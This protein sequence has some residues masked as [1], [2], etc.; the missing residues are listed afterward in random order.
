[1]VCHLFFSFPIS[2]NMQLPSSVTTLAF[3]INSSRYLI[4]VGYVVLLWDTILTFP[5]E[6]ER[7]WRSGISLPKIVFLANK[8]ASLSILTVL[9]RA[10]SGIGVGNGLTHQFCESATQLGLAGGVISL[11]IANYL[12]L[13]QVWQ[14]WEQRPSVRLF[15]TVGWGVTYSATLVIACI[16]IAQLPGLVVAVPGFNVCGLVSVPGLV[17]VIWLSPILFE[18]LVFVMTVSNA[19]DRPRPQHDSIA[20]ALVRDGVFY[21]VSLSML[22]VLNF[23]MSD[24]APIALIPV[25]SCIIWQLNLVALNRLILNQRV[26]LPVMDPSHI[27]IEFDF[28]GMSNV[29]DNASFFSVRKLEVLKETDSESFCE[30]TPGNFRH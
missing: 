18:I 30:P 13:L 21:F 29:H 8:L 27:D 14:L 10:W 12:V 5:D 25:G 9:M 4:A 7:V 28:S 17:R 16:I 19:Y 2:F 24:L 11:G 1:L 22:R 20:R 15:L 23:I 3:E 26:P 6:V